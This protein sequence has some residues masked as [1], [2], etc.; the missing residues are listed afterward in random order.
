LRPLK[1]YLLK[2]NRNSD[3]SGLKF[4]I[5]G[6]PGV[7]RNNLRSIYK[8]KAYGNLFGPRHCTTKIA[9][10]KS[11][12]LPRLRGYLRSNIDYALMVSK[13]KNGSVSFK[14]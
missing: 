5:S 13:S 14:V 2:L 10:P 12:S 7:R 8:N 11:L 4:R 6:R 9:K 1:N 3:I